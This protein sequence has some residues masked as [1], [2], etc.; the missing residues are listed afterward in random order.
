MNWIKSTIVD[1]AVT[2][3]IIVAVFVGE[4]WARWVIWVYTP[5]ILV[6]KI[7]SLFASPMVKRS[8]AKKQA[9]APEW[10]YHILYA[11]NVILLA[12]GGWWWLA[13]GW[14][15]IWAVSFIGARRK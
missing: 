8:A 1:V 2:A 6:L 4:E 5:F 10:F 13:A 14:V 12:V 9:E 3:C 7:G 11:A 15:A